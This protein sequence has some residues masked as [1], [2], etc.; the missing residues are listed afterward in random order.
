MFR[1]L[2]V[3][4]DFCLASIPILRP[5]P[6]SANPFWQDQ[7]QDPQRDQQQQQDQQQDQQY[8]DQGAPYE[9]FS[10]DQLDNLLSPVALYPDPLL[11][12]VLVA[13]TFPDQV[14]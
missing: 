5:A 9:N 8:Q 3:L 1:G 12:Q 2:G 10:P 6:S 14:E 7:Q 13:A 4:V 11:A